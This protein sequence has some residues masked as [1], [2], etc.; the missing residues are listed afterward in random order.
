MGVLEVGGMHIIKKLKIF[1]KWAGER[2]RERERGRKTAAVFIEAALLY[3]NCEV[4][5]LW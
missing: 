4:V 5:I 3:C 2:E 1:K